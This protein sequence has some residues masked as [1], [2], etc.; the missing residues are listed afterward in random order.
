[1]S[2]FQLPV[3]PDTFLDY[4]GYIKVEGRVYMKSDK[5]KLLEEVTWKIRLRKAFSVF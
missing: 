3:I 2:V 4:D 5:K 1:M